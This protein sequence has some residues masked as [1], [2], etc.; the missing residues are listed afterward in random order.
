M[1]R[2]P[3]GKTGES[4]SIIG[5]GGIVVMNVEPAEAGRYVTEAVE[6][7]VNYFDVAPSYGNAEERL[8]PALKPYRDSV[9]LACKTGKRDAAGAEAE[10]QQSLQRLQT[11]HFDLYQLH[12]L[13][14]LEDVDR[15]F[16]PGGAM[17]TFQRARDHGQVR[18]LGFSAHSAEAAVAA[19]ERFNFDSVLFP[20][21]YV[22]Y[23]KE[24]FGPQV[25]AAAERHGAGRLALKGMARTAWPQG[26]DKGPWSK[27]WYE[28]I[29]DPQEADLALRFTLSLPLTAAVPP[30]HVELFR[31]A[32]DIGERFTPLTEEEHGE[33]QK[34]ADP[35]EPLFRVAA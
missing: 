28:P 12:A 31:T 23:Q 6:R 21:N 33:V 16:A 17:E 34:L 18:F 8:G 29:T 2:R 5:F 26:A 35:L 30:G 4:L 9:F 1:E 14:S 10:L 20:F 7:G 32:L 11:D 3:L 25:M 24:G 19:L 13:G 15:V 27:C 22:T